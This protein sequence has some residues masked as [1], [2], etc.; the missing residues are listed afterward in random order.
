MKTETG[1]MNIGMM[2][3]M[4]NKMIK[5]TGGMPDMCAKMMQQIADPANKN[6]NIS[7]AT[8]EIKGLFEEWVKVLEEEIMAFVKEKGKADLSEIA[9]KLKISE[10]STLFFVCKLAKESKLTLGEIR[11][12]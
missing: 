3:E 11:S 12:A 9:A 2:Q 8:A 5:T 10:E 6:E 7:F 4:M 1:G